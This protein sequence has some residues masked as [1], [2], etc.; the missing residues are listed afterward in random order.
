MNAID[1]I[2]IH[3][4]RI[5]QTHLAVTL[6]LSLVWRA[7]PDDVKDA[8][9]VRYPRVDAFLRF[10]R[11]LGADAGGA[12]PELLRIFSRKPEVK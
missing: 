3:Q 9:A 10:A 6:V 7:L 11:K 1:W 5:F 12:L 4:D 2:V 8:I